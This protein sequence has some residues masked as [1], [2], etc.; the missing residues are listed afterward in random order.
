[1]MSQMAER[2]N[3]MVCDNWLLSRSSRDLCEVGRGLYV[4]HGAL[5]PLIK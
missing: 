3:C 1:M 4:V 5:G 2:R